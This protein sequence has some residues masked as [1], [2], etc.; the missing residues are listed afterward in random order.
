WLELMVRQGVAD[1]ADAAQAPAVFWSPDSRR[2]VTYRMNTRDAG[3]LESMQYVPDGQVRP[4]TYRYI[5]PLPG[6]KLPTARPVVFQVG[7]RIRRIDV[8]TA[9]LEVQSWGWGELG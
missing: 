4:R 9:P 3:H 6:E 8:D 1:G 2:L 5:Y 7:K